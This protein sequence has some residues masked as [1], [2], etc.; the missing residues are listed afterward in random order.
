MY[1]QLRNS[2][3]APWLDEVDLLPGEDWE[4]VISRSVQESDVVLV[5]LSKNSITKTGFVQKE[6]KFAL[7]VADQQPENT[8]YLI[9]VKLE[10]CEVPQR[11]SRWQWVDLFKENGYENLVRGLTRR[12]E[13]L[14][15][16]VQRSSTVSTNTATKDIPEFEGQTDPVSNYKEISFTGHDELSKT[17][18]SRLSNNLS[19]TDL[20]TSLQIVFRRLVL[21]GRS[22]AFKRFVVFAVGIFFFGVVDIALF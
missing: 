7:D 16:S 1:H 11:L 9:P 6:I 17:D 18:S 14:G 8:I 12:A 3:F 19:L 13:S 15:L 2:G 21:L 4:L 22:R 20:E 10:E 5:C